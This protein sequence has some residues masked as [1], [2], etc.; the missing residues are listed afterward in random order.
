MAG[1]VGDDEL[2]PRCMEV[3]VCDVDR[4]AVLALRS[5]AVG[6]QCEIHVPVAALDARAYDVLELVLEDLLRVV[7]EAPDQGGLAVVH[8][9]GGGEAHELGRSRIDH[10]AVRGGAPHQK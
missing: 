2:A 4:Y 6:E 1:H 3:A 10:R 5:Q 9:A 7:E 8:R